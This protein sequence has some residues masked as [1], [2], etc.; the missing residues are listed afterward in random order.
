MSPSRANESDEELDKLKS[1]N[2]SLTAVQVVRGSMYC[3]VTCCRTVS[4]FPKTQAE[5][6]D[7]IKELESRVR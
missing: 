7:L 1:V 6:A 5:Q 2:Q 4:P 3:H